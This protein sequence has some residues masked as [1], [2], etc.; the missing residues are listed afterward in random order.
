MHK[1]N[2]VAAIW[3]LWLALAMA[4]P[5]ALAQVGGNAAPATSGGSVPISYVG[6]NARIGLGITDRGDFSGEFLAAFG[7]DGD[8]AFLLDGWLGQ[9]GAAGVKLGYHWLWGGMSRQDSIVRPG[10]VTVAKVFVAVDQNPFDDRKLSAGF[11]LERERWFGNLYLSQGLTDERLTDQV[12]LIERSTLTG[13]TVAGRPFTQQRTLTTI[14]RSFVKAY[15]HGVGARFGRF[16]E[17]AQARATAGLDHEWGDFSSRQTTLSVGL[18]KFIPGSGHSFALT[19]EALQR[20]GD[21]VVDESDNR[22]WLWWRYDFGGAQAYR[23]VEPFREVEVRQEVPAEPLPPVVVRNEVGMDA[24]AFFRIN[25]FALDAADRAELDAVLDVLRSDRRVSRIEVSGHTCDLGPAAYN[26]ALSERRARSVAD[27]LIAAGI[28][29][30]ELDVRGLG[31]AQPKYPND[32]E[33]NRKLNRRVDVTFLTIEETV[34]PVA[35]AEPEVRVT[36]TREPVAAPAAWIERALRNPAAHKR[37]VDVYR[38]ETVERNEVLGPQVLV[39]RPPV[40]VDNAAST[41]RNIAVTIDVLANDTDPD[42][43]ALSIV[44]VGSASNGVAVIAGSRITYTPNPGFRGDDSFSYTISDG[45]LTASATVRVTVTAA[46]P[47]ANPDT[48]STALDTP[49]SL[50]VLSNDRDPGGEALTLVRV[51]TPS[52]GQVTFTAAGVVSYTPRGGFVGTDTFTYGIR[53]AA[54]LEAQSQITIT[55]T[56]AVMPPLPPVAVDD[57]GLVLGA[58]EIAPVVIDVLANDSDP[59]GLAISVV[60]VTQGVRG[61]VEILANGQVRYSPRPNFCGADVFTYTIRNTAGLTASARVF[62]RRSFT[63]GTAAEPKNCPL[64]PV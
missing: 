37:T 27:F 31:E 8:S 4:S 57:Q 11:G 48:A 15:D 51:A 17:G 53:N 63:A 54:G 60:S 22:A 30:G 26:Q 16:F 49:V 9:A 55:V 58:Y 34:Q 25:R 36:W 40:A 47:V 12:S 39:N 6:S 59:R 10:E 13:T 44:A 14:T 38:F 2:R 3:G 41:P 64:P 7:S 1:Q 52:N 20:R 23:A 46:A 19:V 33:P 28:D 5:I 18:E 42:G 62:I 29:S 24:A 21:F 43:D 35:A 45:A 32:G 50:N 61:S 56:A